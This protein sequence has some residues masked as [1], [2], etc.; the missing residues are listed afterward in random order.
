[1]VEVAARHDLSPAE[2]QAISQ[3]LDAYN[4]AATGYHDA[5]D[6]AF[7]AQDGGELVGGLVGYSWGGICE[8]MWLWIADGHRRHG[9]GGRLI[10][11]A[12]A[13][14]AARGCA[15]VQLATYDFQ[16]PDFYRRH[17]FEMIAEIPEK[18]LGH[19][20][21]V[22]RRLLSPAKTGERPGEGRLG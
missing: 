22:M 15:Y 14:A 9:L 12:V 4:A 19:V 21:Y 5:Q 8:V 17:G 1:M 11:A 2:R 6:L 13:E 16:A 20:E 7:V 3:G 10:E 18:P